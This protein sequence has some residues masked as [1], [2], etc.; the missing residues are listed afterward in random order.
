MSIVL[1][2]DELVQQGYLVK[3]CPFCGSLG[4]Q[5]RHYPGGDGVTLVQ[6]E[7]TECGASLGLV[8][9]DIDSA[10]AQWNKRPSVPAVSIASYKTSDVKLVTTGA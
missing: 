9:S 1:T 3:A 7:R 4:V 8:E 2:T 5:V 10:L 6:C